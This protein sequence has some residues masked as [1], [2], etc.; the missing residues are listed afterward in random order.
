LAAALLVAVVGWLVARGGG[1]Q[2]VRPSPSAA[3][4][5]PQPGDV[6]LRQ[7][8]GVWSRFF[9]GLNRRD[10]RFSHA[11]IVIRTDHGWQ[12][13]H[14]EADDLGRDGRVRA[15]AWTVFVGR[16]ADVAVLRLSDP[17]Q[18][19]RLAVAAAALARAGLG[20]DLDFRLDTPDRVYCTELVWRALGEVLGHDPLPNKPQL[21]GRPVVLVENLLL[22]VP[23]LTVV[24]RTATGGA[25]SRASGLGVA[26]T[27]QAQLHLP[28]G[29]AERARGGG[30]VA[31]GIGDRLFQQRVFDGVEASAVG[32]RGQQP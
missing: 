18:Q 3:G 32:R 13:V 7:G 6:V 8:D 20:F 11:G 14:A 2:P 19:E 4:W 1:D 23:E 21:A 16:A 28:A 17:G 29:E 26:V 22:D 15:D 10:R 5:S 12:V 31:I 25:D 24:R 9:A 27:L 30:E